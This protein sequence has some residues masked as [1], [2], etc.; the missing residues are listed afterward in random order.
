[1][2]PTEKSYSLRTKLIVSLVLIIIL[3]NLIM[4][5][6]ASNIMVD[7]LRTKVTESNLYLA[8]TLSG[9]VELFLD[10]P[11]NSLQGIRDYYASHTLLSEQEKA[12]IIKYTLDTHEYFENIMLIG[13]DGKVRNIVPY[14]KDMINLD[15]SGQDFYQKGIVQDDI[16][17]SETF[18]SIH[19]GEPTV[20]LSIKYEQGIIV[21]YL[22]LSFINNFIDKL[23]Q[24]SMNSIAV[25]NNSGTIIAHSDKTK[26]YQR[27][28]DKNYSHMVS[29]RSEGPI[30]LEYVENNIKYFANFSFV[31]NNWAVVVYQN[32]QEACIPVQKI[33]LF[34]FI[35]FSM[36]IAITINISIRNFRLLNNAYLDF[37][38]STKRIAEGAYDK[39][40]S[41]NN[42]Q[43]F[44]LIAEQINF[45]AK[46]IKIR[47]NQLQ[48]TN[49]KLKSLINER[50]LELD[51]AFVL[52]RQQIQTKFPSFEKVKFEQ[53]YLPAKKISGD[54]VFFNKTDD[55]KLIGLI[56]DVCGKGISASLFVSALH[57]LFF[58]SV[59][60][61]FE[62]VKI[63]NYLNSKVEEYLGEQYVAACC[64][65]FDFDKNILQVSSAGIYSFQIK[66]KQVRIEEQII[67]GAFLGMFKDS[68][69]EQKA[70]D[71]QAGDRFYFYSDGFEELNKAEGSTN[72]LNSILSIEE[73][74]KSIE[75]K[76]FDSKTL[77][78]DTTLLFFEVI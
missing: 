3:P 63:L 46:K 45:M 26:V 16:Y 30:T 9:K 2:N 66:K 40:I 27:Y 70:F 1:M 18:L 50:N 8:K 31:N 39:V 49:Q 28:K 34:F 53:I 60:Y 75:R 56:G 36:V 17:F 65:T 7:F 20:A 35:I 42:F 15:V 71:F 33:N 76:I 55:N 68:V 57:V 67:P 73:Q 32:A 21:G 6:S 41:K 47:E 62:P 59:Q 54:F 48:E 72:G 64:F 77:K 11:I 10:E 22:N 61:H 78:D 69:F 13:F 19:T 58:K 4:S 37:V 24:Y 38:Q 23:G 51:Q 44:N 5:I 12:E 29:N 14:N 74:K 52:Q 43:E 25:L